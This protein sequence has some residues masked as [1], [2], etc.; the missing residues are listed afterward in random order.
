MK[1][2]KGFSVL[3]VLLA[4]SLLAIVG[5]YALYAMNPGGQLAKAR[6]SERTAHLNTI[7]NGIRLNM[8]D[9]RSSFDCVSGT[10]PTS[11]IR[12]LASSGSSSYNI[13]PCLVPTYLPLIPHDPS[14]VGAHYTDPTSYDSGYHIQ[15]N[16]TTKQVTLSAPGAELGATITIT[17]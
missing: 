1:N 7:M 17:R 3:E 2:I 16:S 6:N 15:Q 12:R 9:N 8:A 11:T 13:A 4:V 14:M 5:G 10:L